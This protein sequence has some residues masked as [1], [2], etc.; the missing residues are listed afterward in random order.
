MKSAIDW[1]PEADQE[2]EDDL[3]YMRNWIQAIQQDA[4]NSA[5]DDA[6]KK[7]SKKYNA[8]REVKFDPYKSGL[9]DGLDF[10]EQEILSLKSQ[11]LQP[12]NDQ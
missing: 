9:N 11:P 12:T 8:G 2:K 4:R 7:V 3:I 6:A 1:L 10:A 5:L